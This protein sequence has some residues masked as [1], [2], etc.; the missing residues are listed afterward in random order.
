MKKKPTKKPKPK[1]EPTTA[2]PKPDAPLEWHIETKRIGDLEE[3][4]KNPRRLTEKQA[5]DLRTSLKKF[6]YVEP[7]VVN[8]DG[9]SIIGGHQRRRVM[10]QRLDINRDTEVE[11]R[12]P[13]RPLIE[14][15]FEELALRL[16][17]NVGEFDWDSLANNFPQEFL[18]DLGFIP[19]DFGLEDSTKFPKGPEPGEID[20]TVCS[21]CKRPLD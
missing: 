5:E 8:F 15:D 11:V 21:K 4:E 7:I 20:P 19:A 1:V 10:L 6:G 18:M 2:P 3:W 17:K 12:V 9:K 13:N 16:N 14:K